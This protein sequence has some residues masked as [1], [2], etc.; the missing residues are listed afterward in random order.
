M[1]QPKKTKYRK[2]MKGKI[3]V[4]LLRGSKVSFGEY[5]LKQLR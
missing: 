4:L 5:G 2:Q 3:E 1:L